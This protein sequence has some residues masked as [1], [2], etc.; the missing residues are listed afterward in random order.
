MSSKT[1]WRVGFA[2]AIAAAPLGYLS[3]PLDA[4][5]AVPEMV[6]PDLSVRTVVTGLTTPIGVAFLPSRSRGGRDDRGGDDRLG[7]GDQTSADRGE[8]Q[9]ASDNRGSDS[10]G[11][12]D[13]QEDNGRRRRTEMFVIEKSTGQVKLV[14]DGTVTATVL[15]LAVNFASERGLLGIALHPRFPQRPF[16]YLYWTCRTAA[17]PV[18]RLPARR[19]DV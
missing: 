3:R 12:E 17:P 2:I 13:G 1:I 10:S 11:R 16:V 4:Q 6:D 8:L 18:D 5:L 9:T 15:D 7:S 14:V 19:G